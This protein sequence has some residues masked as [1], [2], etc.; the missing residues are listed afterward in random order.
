[1]GSIIVISLALALGTYGI[2]AQ[3]GA[4]LVRLDRYTLIMSAIWGMLELASGFAGYG[5]GRWILADEAV[6]GSRGLRTHVLAGALLAAVGISML[7]QAFR[8]KT[9]LEH[10]MESVDIRTDIL[11]SMKLCL[12]ALL[13]GISCG[14]LMVPLQGFILCVFGFCAVFAGIGYVSGRANGALFTNQAIGLGGGLLFL[15]GVLNFRF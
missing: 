12:Q 4:N 7:L 5:A 15:L 3:R 9:F 13:L 8:K 1:M 10:R 2:A 11:L 14:L 6:S